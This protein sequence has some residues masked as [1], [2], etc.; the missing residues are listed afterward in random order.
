M[1][2]LGLHPIFH[3]YYRAFSIGPVLLLRLLLLSLLLLLLLLQTEMEYAIFMWTVTTT[4]CGLDVVRCCWCCCCCCRLKWR[5]L[6]SSGLALQR[7]TG[8]VVLLLL[9]QTEMEDDVFIWTGT[10]APN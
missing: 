9:L 10:T 4:A 1:L 7:L 8:C 3:W 2:T 5:T 6:S